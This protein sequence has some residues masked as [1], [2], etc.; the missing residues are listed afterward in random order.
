MRPPPD[1]T[2]EVADKH[3]ATCSRLAIT[4][5]VE[6]PRVNIGALQGEGLVAL[7]WTEP[8]KKPETSSP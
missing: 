2:A 6:K 7:D 4:V 1:E 8:S 3:V 5:A